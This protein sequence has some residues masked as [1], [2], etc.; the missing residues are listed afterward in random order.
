MFKITWNKIRWTCELL[1]CIIIIKC[2]FELQGPG[3][4]LVKSCY[5]VTDYYSPTNFWSGPWLNSSGNLHVSALGRNEQGSAIILCRHYLRKLHLRSSK[6]SKPKSFIGAGILLSRLL[7]LHINI[8]LSL[9][10]LNLFYFT[11]LV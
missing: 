2:F 7:T 10:L 1:L 9:D 3:L 8:S 11:F 5:Y 4:F 6:S